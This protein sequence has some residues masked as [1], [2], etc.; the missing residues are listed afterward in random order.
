M[1]PESFASRVAY[2]LEATQRLDLWRPQV[3]LFAL[4][5][6][7]RTW[8]RWDL[9]PLEALIFKGPCVLLGFS[10]DPEVKCEF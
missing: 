3:L 4:T 8:N 9:D 2:G 7:W 10:P 5:F 6:A 1:N